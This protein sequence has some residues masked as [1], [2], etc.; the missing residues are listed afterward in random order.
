MIIKVIVGIVLMTLAI[1]ALNFIGALVGVA[2]V[3]WQ[4]DHERK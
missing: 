2:W 1:L 4:Q 3:K